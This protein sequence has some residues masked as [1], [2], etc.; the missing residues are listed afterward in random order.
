MTK[1]EKRGQLDC[2]VGKTV[3]A[4]LGVE[5]FDNEMAKATTLMILLF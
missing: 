3:D 2:L 5:V 4:V 1:I